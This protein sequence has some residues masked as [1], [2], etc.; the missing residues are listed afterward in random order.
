M[1]SL[2]SEMRL[3]LGLRNF[4]MIKEKNSIETVPYYF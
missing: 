2:D 1:K 4:G 3:K